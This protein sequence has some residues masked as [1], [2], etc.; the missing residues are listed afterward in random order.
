MLAKFKNHPGCI[1]LR[2]SVEL[3]GDL[4]QGYDDLSR[5]RTLFLE[6]ARLTRASRGYLRSTEITRV[7]AR[8]NWHD[9]LV[10]I[11]LEHP[12]AEA[13]R[14]L[15]LWDDACRQVGLTPSSHDRGDSDTPGAISYVLKERLGTGEGSLRTLLSRATRG[16]ADAAEDF[17]EWDT[18]RNQNPRA[19]FRHSWSSPEAPAIPEP[20][21]PR[22]QSATKVPDLDLGLMA[23]LDAL[24]ASTNAQQGVILGLSRRSLQRRRSNFPPARP[25]LIPF[26]I[27]G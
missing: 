12:R 16:D 25:G 3:T 9:H 5:A 11:P 17:L 15:D 27:S 13:G 6:N 4:D 23:M 14:L 22:D 8:W 2:L 26:R 18:W 20:K 7:G 24:G 21:T 19:R 10:V 1:S